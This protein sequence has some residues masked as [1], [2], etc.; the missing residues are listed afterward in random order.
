MDAWIAERAIPTP[1]Y[2]SVG[3]TIAVIS[4]DILHR[5][6]TFYPVLTVHVTQEIAP[7]F[8][9][10]S[11]NKVTPAGLRPHLLCIDKGIILMLL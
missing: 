11:K 5:E 9:W 1:K 3:Q 10:I 6:A 4:Q 7:D 8:P 2:G